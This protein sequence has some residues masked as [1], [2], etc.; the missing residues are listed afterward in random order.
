MKKNE[1]ISFFWK[2][3]A[4][5]KKEEEKKR[6]EGPKGYLTPP[7]TDTQNCFFT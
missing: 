5:K 6:K 4:Q 2:K 1:K 3:K 7:E